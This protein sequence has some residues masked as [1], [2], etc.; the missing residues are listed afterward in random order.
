METDKPQFNFTASTPFQQQPKQP[1]GQQQGQPTADQI[2][3][4]IMNEVGK[5]RQEMIQEFQ[6][7]MGI[8]KSSLDTKQ[9]KDGISKEIK[10]DIKKEIRTEVKKDLKAAFNK[11]SGSFDTA[12]GFNYYA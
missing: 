7:Q 4:F 10:N 1:Q 12:A 6:K 2:K 11:A 5:M 3:Q 9:L 8:I